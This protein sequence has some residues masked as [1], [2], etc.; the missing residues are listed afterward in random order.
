M[1]DHIVKSFDDDMKALSEELSRM[2]KL[3]RDQLGSAID[4][5]EQRNVQLA[6]RVRK[7]DKQV[8]AINAD[9]EERVMTILALR[10]P[11]AVDLRETIAALKIAREL[12]RIG[13]IAKNTAKRTSVI[14][15]SEPVNGIEKLIEMGRLATTTVDAVFNAYAARDVEQALRIRISDQEI[16]TYCNEIFHIVLSGMMTDNSNINA[17]SQMTFIA[18][19]LER[20]GDQVT[21]IAEAIHYVVTGDHIEARRPKNDK[22]SSTAVPEADND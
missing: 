11:V 4:A 20:V 21:N 18:K 15:E 6:K 19:N 14:V 12:E 9:I 7:N 13:D 10:N 5:L 8:D 17:C 3:V 22:T 1:S 16:D 2:G